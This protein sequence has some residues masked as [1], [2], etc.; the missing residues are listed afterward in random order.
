MVKQIKINYD[1]IVVY[2]IETLC[3]CFVAVFIDCKTNKRKEFIFYDDPKYTDQ[4]QKFYDFLVK[5]KDKDYTLMGYNSVY[6]D[7]QVIDTF[8]DDYK[9]RV[10]HSMEELIG[11]I[12]DRAQEVIEYAN[13]WSSQKLKFED[14]LYHNPIDIYKQKHYDGA[15]KRT[16]LKWLQYTMRMSNIQDMPL[17]HNEEIS[18]EQIDDIVKYCIHDVE[19]TKKFF[20][21]NIYETE[22]RENLSKEYGVNVMNNSEPRMSKTIFG[23]YLSEAMGIRYTKLKHMRT[24]RDFIPLKELVLPKVKFSTKECKEALKTV[25]NEVVDA[26]PEMK[27]SFKYEFEYAGMAVDIG[28]G[29]IHA[30]NKPGIYKPEEDEML[31]DVDV[32]SYYPNLAIKNGFYPE[33]L[34]IMKS[35]HPPS[36]V[37]DKDN[38]SKQKNVFLDIYENLY[39][40]RKVIPKSDPRNYIFKIILNSKR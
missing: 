33:H 18:I 13:D 21:L 25:N 24:E 40:M 30:C 27:H 6:F 38:A 23:K 1:R 7:G 9:N 37:G 29:G 35:Q 17:P 20:E 28:L 36:P 2:D 39:E 19:S 4:P 11:A 15:A 8:M 31:L 12:Y 3:N 32:R 5:L 34:G 26:R 16:S 22:L 14:R 10:H